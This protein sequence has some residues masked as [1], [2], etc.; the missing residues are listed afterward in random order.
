MSHTFV[1]RSPLINPR[2]LDSRGPAGPTHDAYKLAAE[3]VVTIPVPGGV[4]MEFAEINLTAVEQDAPGFMTAWGGGDKPNT[5]VLNWGPAIPTCN[6][7]TV[8]LLNGTFQLISSARTHV[9]IDLV[10]F[11]NAI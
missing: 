5:S 7:I 2:I 6:Q 3:K 1:P 8:P 4:G 10:G 9:I 11:F